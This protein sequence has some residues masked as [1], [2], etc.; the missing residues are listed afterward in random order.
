MKLIKDS[1][2]YMTY[3]QHNALQL[4]A[5][6]CCPCATPYT[7][8]IIITGVKWH[9]PKDSASAGLRVDHV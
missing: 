1:Q 5:S 4:L 6:C 7:T 2:S 9:L 3:N 8:I